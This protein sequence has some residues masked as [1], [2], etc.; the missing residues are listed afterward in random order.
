MSWFR[1]TTYVQIKQNRECR[2]W[3]QA[4]ARQ[5]WRHGLF[6]VDP[7]P[8][9]MEKNNQFGYPNR[10]IPKG[11]FSE[12]KPAQWNGNPQ[13]K[14]GLRLTDKGRAQQKAL[15]KGDWSF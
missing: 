3:V 8:V 1:Y 4:I 15:E 14:E 6:P 2:H 9:F 13:S 7:T 11:Q 10:E 12:Q 5:F